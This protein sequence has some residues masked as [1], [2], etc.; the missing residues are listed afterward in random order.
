MCVYPTD[1]GDGSDEILMCVHAQWVCQI[2]CLHVWVSVC[3][4]VCLSSCM[5]SVHLCLTLCF[6][7][8]VYLYIFQLICPSFLGVGLSLSVFN[9]SVY[10][11]QSVCPLLFLIIGLHACLSVSLILCVEGWLWRKKTGSCDQIWKVIQ[12]IQKNQ[13]SKWEAKWVREGEEVI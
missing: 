10:I 3:L 12:H 6:S 13:A 8:A 1:S 5:S 7:Q 11:F 2:V 9:L 4:S